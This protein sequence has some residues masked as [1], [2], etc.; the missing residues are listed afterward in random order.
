MKLTVL[1]KY[2][3]YPPVG[4]AGPGY[5]VEW[6]DQGDS[7]SS[8]GVLLDCGP[9]VL[10]RFQEHVGPLSKIHTVILSHLHFDHI[11]DVTVLRY[12]AAADGRYRELPHHVR[13]YAPC[14]PENEFSLLTYKEATSGH[15]L[16]SGMSLQVGPLR[17]TFHQG[18][19]GIPSFA[20]RVEGPGGVLAY[21]GDTRP[22]DALVEAAQGADLFLCEASG[23][24][25]DADYVAPGHL[26]SRQAGEIASQAGVKRL[27]LTHIW[28]LYDEHELLRECRDV[29]P[30]SELAQEGR[31][32][33][34]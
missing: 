12:A 8:T 17:L 4:G 5:W 2:S 28:P 7:G 26:T 11:S 21:S 32:Y 3:P 23:V 30:N 22:C 10:A 13:I 18:V 9:G 33:C 25:A 20:V 24:Q 34:L 31:S 1:G 6:G 29:F 19:H 14:Q 15:A 16:S 27:L